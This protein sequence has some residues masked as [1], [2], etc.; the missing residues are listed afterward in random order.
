M[1]RDSVCIS[2]IYQYLRHIDSS[3]TEE[4]ESKY[5]PNK[6]LHVDVEK[7]LGD[8][9]KEEEEIK[10]VI[11][12]TFNEGEIFFFWTDLFW[13]NFLLE[14]VL[15]KSIPLLPSAFCVPTSFRR[16]SNQLLF[17]RMALN[18]TGMKMEVRTKGTKMRKGLTVARFGLLR[19]CL[20]LVR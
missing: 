19:H 12:V 14:V 16:H 3:L 13:R 18:D 8:W 1:M 2:V 7:L 10:M 11:C 17:S 9:R 15:G 20:A 5:Q 4:F 6:D